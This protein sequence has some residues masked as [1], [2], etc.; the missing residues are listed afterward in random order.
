MDQINLLADKIEQA[1]N[2]MFSYT[3]EQD[4]GMWNYSL[5]F[6]SKK[7][8]NWIIVLF[9]KD[10]VQLKCSLKNG[11]CYSVYQFLLNELTLIDKQMP[12]SI[13][14]ETEN[15]P[16]NKMEYEQLL[17]KHTIIYDTLN[18]EKGKQQNCSVCGHD[19]NKHELRGYENEEGLILEGWM[20]CPSEDCTCFMTW[21]APLKKEN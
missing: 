15:P 16:S 5:S 12:V 8:K 17:E 18:D 13:R 21:D 10:M 11:F 19:W 3:A 4:S 14:F 20:I 9:F 6:D 1:I 7:S 2:K